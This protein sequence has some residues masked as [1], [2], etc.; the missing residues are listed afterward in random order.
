MPRR[1]YY[2]GSYGRWREDQRPGHRPGVAAK[3]W[4]IVLAV[5]AAVMGL[6]SLA[7]SFY[8]ALKP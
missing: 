5:L 7:Q 6:A 2:R 4:V 8:H 1:L 3:I